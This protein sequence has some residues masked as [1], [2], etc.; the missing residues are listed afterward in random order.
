MDSSLLF[1]NLCVRLKTIAGYIRKNKLTFSKEEIECIRKAIELS[2]DPVSYTHLDV[3][4][5]QQYF[6]KEI[7]KLRYI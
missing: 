3:Y 7:A 1:E 4:K 2:P 6:R 5:R